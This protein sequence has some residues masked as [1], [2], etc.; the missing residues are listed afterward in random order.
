MARTHKRGG[1]PRAVYWTRERVLGALRLYRAEFGCAPRCGRAYLARLPRPGMGRRG[2]YPSMSAVLR[3]FPAFCQAWAAAG[4]EPDP[5]PWHWSP[6]EEWYLREAAG[7]LP[8]A[9][10]AADLGRTLTACRAHLSKSALLVTDLHGWH[11]WRLA[12]ALDPERPKRLHSRLWRAMSRGQLPFVQGTK[13]C[14]PSLADLPALP[15]LAWER[16]TPDLERAVRQALFTRIAT[17]LAASAGEG[18]QGESH[19]CAEAGRDTARRRSPPEPA[20]PSR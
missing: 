11:T 3:H 7:I 4:V 5:D 6:T 13:A 20:E 18:R 17:V 12:V 19:A 2:V 8:L 16:A 9:V 14:W 10:V 15:G 1:K